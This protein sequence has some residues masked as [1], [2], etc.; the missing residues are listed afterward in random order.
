MVFFEIKGGLIQI[1]QEWICD[2]DRNPNHC[3]PAYQ[4]SVLQNG[5]DEKSAG[6]NY[7]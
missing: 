6:I 4:F 2:F 7:R 5:D 1:R 3:T